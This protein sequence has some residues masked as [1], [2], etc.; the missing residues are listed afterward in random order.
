M[1]QID[2]YGHAGSR[3]VAWREVAAAVAGGRWQKVRQF[4]NLAKRGTDGHYEETES[5]LR[6][7]V[8]LF[9]HVIGDPA[10]L[11]TSITQSRL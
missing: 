5:F 10:D 1:I 11:Q 6:R 8:L 7:V 3:T 4:A 2:V 9:Y